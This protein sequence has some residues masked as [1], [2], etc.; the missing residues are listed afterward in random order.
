MTLTAKFQLNFIILKII[1]FSR[2][3]EMY[4][5][6]TQFLVLRRNI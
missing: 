6:K 5:I 4:E 3:M 1:I 2:K